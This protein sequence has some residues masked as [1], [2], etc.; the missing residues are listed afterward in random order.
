MCCVC[1]MAW[2]LQRKRQYHTPMNGRTKYHSNNVSVLGRGHSRP[3]VEICVGLSHV[4]ADMETTPQRWSQ[5]MSYTH[6]WSSKRC[7][8]SAAKAWARHQQKHTST[9]N[10]TNKTT[11]LKEIKIN[12]QNKK[13]VKIKINIV[14]YDISEGQC[15]VSKQFWNIQ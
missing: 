3:C 12:T 5:S 2:Y 10:F 13:I 7:S 14:K 8:L 9:S 11:W 1:E 15:E 4:P 6:G